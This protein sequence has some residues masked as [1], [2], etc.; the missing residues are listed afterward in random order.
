[1][2]NCPACGANVPTDARACPGCGAAIPPE[3]TA[4][5]GAAPDGPEATGATMECPNCGATVP[6]EAEA[7]PACG[8]LQ[9]AA[10]CEQHPDRPGVG[11]C[12]VCGRVLCDGCNEGKGREFICDVHKD[13]EIVEGWAEVYST[14]DDIEADLIR[15][16][17]R[18]EG[19]DAQVLSQRDHYG[20]TIAMGDLAVVRVLVPA[21]EYED[22]MRSLAEHEDSTGEVA[23]ACPACGTPFQAG[24]TT[25][26]A[27][28][29]S[30]VE[31][32]E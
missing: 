25:C 31:S 8:R 20:I 26:G 9:A 21:Y 17:L 29:A 28:G 1:M 18:A 19:I 7:C 16:N 24:E 2:A 6:E 32:T 4:E 15:D 10:P 13:V 12:V 3:P 5:I 23:M 11:A 30:L 27:C 22:A 14:G